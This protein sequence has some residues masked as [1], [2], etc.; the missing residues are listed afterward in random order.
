MPAQDAYT[1]G[2]DA[3]QPLSGALAVMGFGTPYTT[4]SL[5]G[6]LA[7]ADAASVT[8]DLERASQIAMSALGDHKPQTRIYVCGP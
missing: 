3:D 7:L 5:F 4:R 8:P 2:P 1:A 6:A